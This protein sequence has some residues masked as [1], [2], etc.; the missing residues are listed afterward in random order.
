LLLVT[1]SGLL[2]G[3]TG[4]PLEEPDFGDRTVQIGGT[5]GAGGS[6][7]LQGSNDGTNWVAVTDPKG[8]P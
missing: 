7:T 8:P 3:D 6:V 2:N 1:W 5:F 4:T